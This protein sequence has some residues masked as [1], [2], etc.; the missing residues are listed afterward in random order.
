MVLW[1]YA[2]SA[3]EL[4]FFGVSCVRSIWVSFRV[5]RV[6]SFIWSV[7]E[8]AGTCIQQ[9]IRTNPRTILLAVDPFFRTSPMRNLGPTTWF[10]AFEGT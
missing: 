6:K 8:L 4:G 3:H 2:P 7:W 5:G 10:P 9:Q 1:D